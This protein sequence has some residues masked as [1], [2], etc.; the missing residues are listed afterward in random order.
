VS[1]EAQLGDAGAKKRKRDDEADPKLEEFLE[2]MN[3]G[4]KLRDDGTVDSTAVVPEALILPEG[5]ESD[6]EY[7]AL[8]PRAVP[9]HSE[10]K[11][12]DEVR[13]APSAPV[14]MVDPPPIAEVV[15]P[16]EDVPIAAD[17]SDGSWLRSRTN[18]LLDL[19]DPDDA[20]VPVR[21]STKIEAVPQPVVVQ[22][23]DA[24]TE[25]A[26]PVEDH[27]EAP[28]TNQDTG[29]PVD[30]ISSTAR[31][32]VRNLPYAA[33]ADEIRVHFSAFGP[34]EEVRLFIPF[35]LFLSYPR[36]TRL[37]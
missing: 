11:P 36:A 14:M 16:R 9:T 1:K 19:V 22:P 23:T 10:E 24:Q 4:K 7:E 31:I 29:S 28:V 26:D 21:P 8:P 5:E 33:T 32:F 35:F 18:R 3:P 37:Q 30:L 17:D 2:V 15:V 12:Q 20:S 25:V 27:D 34:V 6:D 13:D